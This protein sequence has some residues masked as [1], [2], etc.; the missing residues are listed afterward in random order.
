MRW[1]LF[2]VLFGKSRE[3]AL[4]LVHVY[5]DFSWVFHSYNNYHCWFK[6]FSWF[7]NLY[8]HFCCPKMLLSS[9]SLLS[10]SVYNMIVTL[11]FFAAWTTEWYAMTLCY[12]KL[13]IILIRLRWYSS[14]LC[15]GF[16]CMEYKKNRHPVQFVAKKSLVFKLMECSSKKHHIN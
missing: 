10:S 13:I 3:K 8:L 2:S 7:I 4:W 5:G 6:N 12:C 14:C 9:S 15:T 16:R 1:K 11:T